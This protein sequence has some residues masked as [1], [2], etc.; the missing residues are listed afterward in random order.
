MRARGTL[1]AA[2][3]ERKADGLSTA[4]AVEVRELELGIHRVAEKE[5]EGRYT[6]L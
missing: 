5:G 4:R 2:Y 1:R 6:L 3:V